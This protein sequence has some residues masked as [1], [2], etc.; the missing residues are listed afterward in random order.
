MALKNEN[1]VNSSVLVYSCR[2]W[3]GNI[4]LYDCEEMICYIY[5][6]LSQC[7]EVFIN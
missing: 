4:F 1:L 7:N 2:M 3:C 6:I 5:V